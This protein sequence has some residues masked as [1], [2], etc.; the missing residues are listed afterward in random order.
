[1]ATD[2]TT[3]VIECINEVIKQNDLEE[4]TLTPETSILAETSL[5]SL[6]LAE[7]IVYLEA[8][9]EKDPFSNG[10]I[11]FQTVKE[12]AHLYEQ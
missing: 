6:A 1:M 11:N 2:M 12:L 3:I 10:F 8:K 7:V 9:T 4:S 5:D